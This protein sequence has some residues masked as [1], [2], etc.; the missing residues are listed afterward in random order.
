MVSI[1]RSS[2]LNFK[3]IIFMVPSTFICLNIV[4]SVLSGSKN[5]TK[6]ANPGYLAVN[7]AKAVQAKIA[8]IAFRV[9]G[10]KISPE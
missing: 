8:T 3:L 5:P 10:E 7:P 9:I 2:V 1:R 4:F 6:A